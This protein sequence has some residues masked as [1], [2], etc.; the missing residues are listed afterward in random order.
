MDKDAL[1]SYHFF[2]RKYLFEQTDILPENYHLPEGT[3]P[4]ELIK[5]HAR[6]YEQQIADAGGLDIQILGIGTNGHI[7]FNEPGSYVNSRT[8]LVTLD[9]STR[10]ANS[11]EFG[12][13]N[14]VPRMAITMGMGTILE[15]RKIILM[16][17]GSS[18]APVIKKR[19][20]EKLP[21]KYRHPSYKPMETLNLF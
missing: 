4:K 1:Q 6:Q 8:R 9:N 7:G 17:W 13:L 20:K 3:T 5:E 14:Q 21:K 2:M 15:A 19:W 16:A 11:H 10:I 12:N 18:K